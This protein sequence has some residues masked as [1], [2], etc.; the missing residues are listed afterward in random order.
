MEISVFVLVLLSAALHAGWNAA[1]K[2]QVD[3]LSLLAAIMG[4]CSCLGLLAVLVLP[5]LPTALVPYLIG[6]TA[7]HGLY[8]G[9][10]LWSYR[11]GD[12]SVVYPIAR[13]MAPALVS[14]LSAW[15]V[16][17]SLR[18]SQWFGVALVSF[19]IVIVG[20]KPSQGMQHL[21]GVVAAAVTGT[22]IAAYTFLDGLGTRV[23]PSPYVF[24]A[25][26]FL[27]SGLPVCV[28]ALYFRR[29]RIRASL[30][31]VGSQ[32]VLGG[33]IAGSGYSIVL[34]A[35]ST[36]PMGLVASLR[37]T[38]VVFAA[39]IGVFWLK[40]ALGLQRIIGSVVVAVGVAALSLASG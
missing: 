3:Q 27:L 32:G 19:G 26:Q 31:Q 35:L 8:H 18:P 5:P 33:L 25:W 23:M 34:W 15:L 36:A 9:A 17:E 24:I 30:K 28:A 13:G 40:E 6:S 4:T 11:H 14:L 38:G 21:R 2:Q 12:L 7:L 16:H 22:L 1:V 10:L 39:L 20:L 37:E 29:G